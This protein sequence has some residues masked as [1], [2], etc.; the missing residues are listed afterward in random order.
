MAH[1]CGLCNKTDDID[2][3]TEVG[4]YSDEPYVPDPNNPAFDICVTCFESICDSLFEF[5]EEDEEVTD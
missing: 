5:E 3:E 2:V 4:D 1:R